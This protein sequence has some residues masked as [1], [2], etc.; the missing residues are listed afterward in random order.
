MEDP[1]F[2]RPVAVFTGL[3]FPREIETVLDAYHFLTEWK[4]IPDVDQMGAM[5]V[6]R[7]ALSGAR[8]GHEARMAFQRFAR[9]R[10]IVAEIA[11]ARAATSLAEEWSIRRSR[12]TR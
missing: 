6:C 7:K 8:T 10:G 1:Q 4:A 2:D 12:P 5:E 3:G 9:N 11:C